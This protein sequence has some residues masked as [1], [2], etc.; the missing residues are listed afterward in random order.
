[1]SIAGGFR[2]THHEAGEPPPRAPHWNAN[3][4]LSLPASGNAPSIMMRI[5]AAA[6]GSGNFR[7][8]PG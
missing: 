7:I 3:Q 5:R 6:L 1:M 8:A 4:A 2:I